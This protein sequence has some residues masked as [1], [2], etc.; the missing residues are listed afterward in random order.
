M[1]R[2]ELSKKRPSRPANRPV[3]PVHGIRMVAGS[4]TASSRYYYC[5][6]PDCKQSK[7]ESRGRD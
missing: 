4:T 6:H 1:R 7:K 2:F 5:P 3:C